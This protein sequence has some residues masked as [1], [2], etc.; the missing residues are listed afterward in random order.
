[1]SSIFYIDG[2]F[3]REEDATI[4]ASDL[5]VLRGYGVFDYMRTYNGHPFYLDAH[6]DRLSNSAQLIG[7]QL[8]HSQD[9]I[10]QIILDTIARNNHEEYNVRI[11]VTGGSSPDNIIPIGE[12]RL[13]VYITP[14]KPMPQ[15]WYTD[16]IKVVTEHSERA[17]PQAKTINYIPAI[18]ALNRASAVQALDA[19][20][21]TPDGHVLEGTTTNIFAFI[22]DTLVT[23]EDGILHGITR[24]VALQLAAEQFKVETRPLLLDELLKADEVFLTSSNKEICPIRQV[25]DQVFTAPGPN[26]QRLMAAFTA[27]AK[28]YQ[29]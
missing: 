17:I 25:D 1:M 2:E 16:G 28:A 13:L 15:E 11:V 5:S 8:P 10:R 23:A 18:I 9:E 20:Y 7:L 14:F 4:A 22:G 19:I 12:S 29:G 6:L 24:R 21:V 27:Y 3:V 26:T